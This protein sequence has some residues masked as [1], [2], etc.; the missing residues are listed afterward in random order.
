[1]PAGPNESANGYFEARDLL[2]PCS[3]LAVCLPRFLSQEPRAGAFSNIAVDKLP[4]CVVLCHLLSSPPFP[5]AMDTR[6]VRH[7]S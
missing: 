4:F 3:D 1:M 6:I 5:E 7:T 2:F